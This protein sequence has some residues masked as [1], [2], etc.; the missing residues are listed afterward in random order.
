MHLI[1]K[2]VESCNLF[3]YIDYVVVEE[4]NLKSYDD[5]E[6]VKRNYKLLQIIRSYSENVF[7]KNIIPIHSNDWVDTRFTGQT[8]ALVI[9]LNKNGKRKFFIR[10]GVT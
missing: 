7:S 8:S 3:V 10:G 9:V 4:V 1:T 6:Q 2:D 5:S